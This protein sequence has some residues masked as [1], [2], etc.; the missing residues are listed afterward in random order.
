M[1]HVRIPGF[2]ANVPFNKMYVVTRRQRDSIPAALFLFLAA[3]AY[4]SLDS[5]PTL[6]GSNSS[7]GYDTRYTGLYPTLS[8]LTVGKRK[9]KPGS[10]YVLDSNGYE[11]TSYVWLVDPEEG[12]VR[13]L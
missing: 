1:R 3:P 7:D 4:I 8:P 12:Q 13:K 10:L 5:R 9:P 11:K 6:Q 2:D